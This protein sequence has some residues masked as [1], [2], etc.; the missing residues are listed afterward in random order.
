MAQHDDTT[1]VWTL[2]HDVVLPYGQLGVCTVVHVRAY[3][4]HFGEAAV[5]IL[6]Q[7]G[8]FV[9]QSLTNSI[10]QAAAAAQTALYPDGRHL[11]IIQHM[12]YCTLDHRKVPEFREV[13]L[14][15]HRRGPLRR[16]W[17]RRLDDRLA[18]SAVAA[19]V[20]GADGA[21][22]HVYPDVRPENLPWKFTGP[23]WHQLALHWPAEERPALPEMYP[24]DL[25]RPAEVEIP[26]V[27]GHQRIQVWPEA[28]YTPELIG[29]PSV[30]PVSAER[31]AAV[32]ARNDATG[33]FFEAV[34]DREPGEIV[35]LHQ[36]RR[37]DPTQNQ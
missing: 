8:H 9:G 24:L 21:I 37:D 20:V 12:P 27:L 16:W 15:R 28:L 36:V 11:R 19:T 32:R 7:F 26:D 35:E 4:R 3:E 2:K 10:E 25:I 18:R 5:V 14:A 31:N 13:H 30:L 33:A 23:S 17:Q 22:R 6:G 34:T 1:S 29:G